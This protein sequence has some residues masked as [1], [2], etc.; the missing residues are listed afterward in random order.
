[1]DNNDNND[2]EERYTY[3]F[4]PR[5]VAMIAAILPLIFTIGI[6]VG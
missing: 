2:R 6:L 5:L 4:K 1:V 3:L